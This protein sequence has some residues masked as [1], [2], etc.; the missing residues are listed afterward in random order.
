MRAFVT[1]E[2]IAL[3]ADTD[4]TY[5]MFATA[6]PYARRKLFTQI[7]YITLDDTD[8]NGAVAKAG[9]W[10][11]GQDAPNH[12]WRQ[13]L[14]FLPSADMCGVC[15]DVTTPRP[16]LREDGTV[17]SSGFNEQRTYS[18]WANSAFARAGEDAATCQD[19]H[20]PAVEDVAGCAAFSESGIVHPTGGRRHDLAGV[21]LD[22]TSILQ[23]NYGS[24][25]SDEIDDVFFDPVGTCVEINQCVGCTVRNRHRHAIEQASPPWRERS[26]K[27]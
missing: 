1:L 17:I 15:H 19:C 13:D 24:A 3:S 4:G 27:F 12:P 18:E 11:Y 2:G 20:M 21:H 23:K 14:E 10:S 7:G 26:V 25:G 8:I 9:P 16:R 5:D 6:A 22:L